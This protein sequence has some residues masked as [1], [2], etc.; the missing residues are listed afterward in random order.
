MVKNLVAKAGIK[1]EGIILFELNMF[2]SIEKIMPVCV[3]SFIL[4]TANTCIWYPDQREDRYNYCMKDVDSSKYN[5]FI[6]NDP[7]IQTLIILD[8]IVTQKKCMKYKK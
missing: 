3:S 4:L 6:H 5:L 1:D 8:Y 7:K 2:A